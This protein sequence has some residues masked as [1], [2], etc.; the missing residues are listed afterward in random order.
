MD[1]GPNDQ[2]LTLGDFSLWVYGRSYPDSIDFWDGNWLQCKA[3]VKV[4][5]ASVEVV[6]TFLRN[7]ELMDFMRGLSRMHDEVAGTAE[8]HCIE[9]NLGMAL[10]TDALGH[11]S[12]EV[13]ITPD[14]MAQSHHFSFAVDQTF[15]P[16]LIKSCERVLDRFPIIGKL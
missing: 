2:Y 10:A 5:G 13:S 11:I 4:N 15:L 1:S 12:V 3:Q 7:D 6:G 16:P 14:H 8:L 9:P